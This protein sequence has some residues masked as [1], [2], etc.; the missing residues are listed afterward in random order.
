MHLKDANEE[1]KRNTRCV[2]QIESTKQNVTN[3]S[4]ENI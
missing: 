4:N 2:G 1:G 3:Q